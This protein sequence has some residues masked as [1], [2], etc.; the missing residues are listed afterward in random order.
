MEN[1]LIKKYLD[2]IF[3]PN[4][5]TL[6]NKQKKKTKKQSQS[7]NALSIYEHSL[8]LNDSCLDGD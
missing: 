2:L 4:C 3:Y 1:L 6:P 7:L 8:L 5:F